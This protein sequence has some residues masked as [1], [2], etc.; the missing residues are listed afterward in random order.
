VQYLSP[1]KNKRAPDNI[2]I[3]FKIYDTQDFPKGDNR[4]FSITGPHGY[5]KFMEIAED[6]YKY[7][8][9]ILIIYRNG[10]GESITVDSD[11]VYQKCLKDALF[12]SFNSR[13]EVSLYVKP[14]KKKWGGDYFA[15]ENINP[16]SRSIRRN[17]RS[18]WAFE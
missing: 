17:D 4:E 16:W 7:R 12:D 10:I 3:T 15:D 5:S 9:P 13:N 2:T 18:T 8:L 11:E 1:Y 14:F 6:R